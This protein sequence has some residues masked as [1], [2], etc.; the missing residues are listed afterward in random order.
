MTQPGCRNGG[1][2]TIHGHCACPKGV[3]G[4]QCET[5]L[6]DVIRPHC[7]V[8]YHVVLDFIIEKN[9]LLDEYKIEA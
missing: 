7:K 1:V 8:R 9:E 4:A 5:V 6:C 2:C 3:V